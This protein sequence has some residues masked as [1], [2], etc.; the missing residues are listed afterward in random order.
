M[1]DN[2]AHKL[3]TITQPCE[4]IPHKTEKSCGTKR[5]REEL[6]TLYETHFTDNEEESDYKRARFGHNFGQ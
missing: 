2:R 3:V 6:T 5:R 1:F 4:K